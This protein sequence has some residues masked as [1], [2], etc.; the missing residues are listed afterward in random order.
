MG[1]NI[2]LEDVE[3]PPQAFQSSDKNSL[4]DGEGEF[5]RNYNI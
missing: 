5:H 3:D 4:T 1:N 2:L